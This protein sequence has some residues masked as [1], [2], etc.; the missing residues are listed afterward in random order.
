[1]M[2]IE[3][4]YYC[5]TTMNINIIKILFYVHVYYLQEDLHKKSPLLKWNFFRENFPLDVLHIQGFF[6]FFI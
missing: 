6:I 1:M 3:S 5:N 2:K 4:Y